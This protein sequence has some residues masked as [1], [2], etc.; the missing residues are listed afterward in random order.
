MDVSSDAYE[1]KLYESA[2][3]WL[4]I[5]IP[6]KHYVKRDLEG[7]TL[8]WK[9]W[10]LQ[11]ARRNR[12]LIYDLDLEKI[13]LIINPEA[14]RFIIECYNEIHSPQFLSENNRMKNGLAW[15]A[16]KEIFKT[17]KTHALF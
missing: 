8:F 2:L 10:S 4:N 17:E 5:V 11:W 7:S 13:D 9:W 3:A 12:D 14:Q 15:L 1:D 6:G 16:N